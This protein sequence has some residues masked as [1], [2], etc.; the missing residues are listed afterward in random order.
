LRGRGAKGTWLS[1]LRDPGPAPVALVGT[2]SGGDAG[3]GRKKALCREWLTRGVWVAAAAGGADGRAGVSGVL[4]RLA[5]PVV[6]SRELG[7]PVRD[8]GLVSRPS[9][10]SRLRGFLLFCCFSI[11][12]F[13]FFI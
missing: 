10:P 12:F 11:L 4:G 1:D 6:R 7:Q 3:V 2:R 9:R 8:A 5:G 13:F